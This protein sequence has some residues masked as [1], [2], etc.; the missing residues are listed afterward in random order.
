VLS[1]FGDIALAIGGSFVKYL[2]STLQMLEQ[3]ARTKVSD[4]D[5]EI[6]EYMAMLREGILEA[7]IGVVQGLNDG[8]N[9]GMI[10]PQLGVIFQFL[11]VT[12]Q[13]NDD[14]CITKNSIGLI[15]D[16]AVLLVNAG[17]VAPYFRQD[18]VNELIARGLR[19][20]NIREIALWTQMKLDDLFRL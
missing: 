18:F 19:Q 11:Q 16:L 5:D 1:C 4:A 8:S 9:Y 3:A 15:G 20:D 13:E 6:I 7:Y 12:S 10:H 17:D 14:E 2:P